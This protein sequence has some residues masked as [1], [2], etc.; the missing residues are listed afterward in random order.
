MRTAPLPPAP[1][2]ARGWG[3]GRGI[4]AGVTSFIVLPLSSQER[5]PGGE[6][7]RMKSTHI[8]I[9]LLAVLAFT[10]HAESLSD[11][12]KSLADANTPAN[13]LFSLSFFFDEAGRP[14]SAL[15]AIDRAIE[16]DATVPGYFARKGQLLLARKRTQEAADAYGH[17]ADMDPATKSFRGAQARAYANCSMNKEASGAWEKLLKLC[18][19][20]KEIL[21]AAN[22]LAALQK[23]QFDWYAAEKAWRT[24]W[25]KLDSWDDRLHAAQ[26]LSALQVELQ[27]TQRVLGFWQAWFNAEKDWQHAMPI[28]QNLTAYAAQV[29]DA[30]PEQLSTITADW[31]SVLTLAPNEEVRRAAAVGFGE[32]CISR[33]RPDGVSIL[34]EMYREKPIKDTDMDVI[35]VIGRAYSMEGDATKIEEF[36]RRVLNSKLSYEGRAEAAT[37]LSAS[38]RDSASAVELRRQLAKDFPE[39]FDA[40]TAFAQA[41]TAAKNFDE[42]LNVYR[43]VLPKARKD[44]ENPQRVLSIYDAMVDVCA[45]A[46]DADRA[47]KLIVE[48]LTGAEPWYTQRWLQLLNST[49]G[50]AAAHA[51]AIRIAEAGGARR[52]GAGLYL[53]NTDIMRARN[54]LRDA[55]A[56]AALSV[57]QRYQ[58]LN[59]L[60]NYSRS[61]TESIGYTRRML[62]LPTVHWTRY[63]DYQ[64]L[65]V[66]LGQEGLVKDGIDSV[67]EAM[68]PEQPDQNIQSIAPNTL[69]SLGLNIW[70]GNG[71]GRGLR[72]AEQLQEAMRAATSLYRERAGDP[73]FGGCFDQLCQTLAD[74]CARRGDLA[75]GV[76]FLDD[77]CA[78]V[79]SPALHLDAAELL[80]RNLDDFGAW[81]EYLA[82][83][84][85]LAAEINHTL[86]LNN[87]RQYLPGL[88]D[89]F[90]KFVT[91]KKKT[92]D[93]RRHIVTAMDKAQGNARYAQAD[94]LLGFVRAAGKPEDV[95][96][97]LKELQDKQIDGPFFKAQAAW[98]AGAVKM[99][100]STSRADTVAREQLLAS[101]ESWK[102]TLDQN[103]EDYQ[104][105]INLYKV[106][107]QLGR[108]TDGQPFL[109]KALQIAPKDPLVLECHARELMLDKKYGEAARELIEAAHIA[110]RPDDVEATIESAY[111]LS[112]RHAD[113]IK[114]ALDS[115]SE[116]HNNG[117]GIRDA[118]AI[119]DLAERSNG[120]EQL[121]AELMKRFDSA[122][123]DKKFV[124]ESV[125]RLGLRV[126]WERHDTDVATRALDALLALAWR[127]GHSSNDESRWR[128]LSAQAENRRQINDAI[129]IQQALMTA[130]LRRQTMPHVSEYEQLARLMILADQPNDAADL[131][132]DGMELALQRRAAPLSGRVEIPWDEKGG[133]R[134]GRASR[135]VGQR[136]APRQ[137]D[138]QAP[139]VRAILGL[140]ANEAANGAGRFRLAGGHRFATL[141]DAELKDFAAHPADY[142]GALTEPGLAVNLGV[143]E[144]MEA[145]FA[146]PASPETSLA[147]AE[148][149]AK[150]V[151]GLPPE[152]RPKNATLAAI[153]SACG[154][155]LSPREDRSIN[156][157]KKAE[158]AMRVAYLYESLLNMPDETRLPGVK[159]ELALK[160]YDAAAAAAPARY[161]LEATRAALMLAQRLKLNESVLTYT[162]KLH[163]AYPGCHGPATDFAE[164]LLANG[165]A[166]EAIVLLRQGLSADDSAA[167]CAGP[168]Y[169][170]LTLAGDSPEACDGA[171][172]FFTWALAARELEFGTQLDAD[173]KPLLDPERG[174]LK[175][176]LAVA[177][178]GSAKIDQALKAL[179]EASVDAPDQTF[180]QERIKRLCVACQKAGRLNDFL[181]AIDAKIKERPHSLPLRLARADI[182]E[183]SG[184]LTA[185]IETLT[186]AKAMRAELSTVK[187]LI[188]AQRKSGDNAAALAE[189]R[190]WS[191][192]FPWDEEAHRTLAAIYHDL[193]DPSGEIQALT[194]LVESAPREAAQCRAVAAAMIERKDFS[195]ARALLER[196][197]EL[198][199]E[200]PWR[201][202]DLAEACLLMQDYAKAGELCQDALTRDWR[203]GLSPELLARTP[204]WTGTF[205]ARA[206]A[207]LAEAC[208]AT[209]QT[210]KAA[211]ERMQLPAGYKRPAFDKAAPGTGVLTAGIRRR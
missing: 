77:L 201:V 203:K 208:Q 48:E 101:L 28:M 136:Y 43:A 49:C 89:P 30:T 118:D 187:R 80:Q 54:M 141:L 110:G 168:G 112:G 106:Y 94:L 83:N 79:D 29:G 174:V 4:Y 145:A 180:E 163:T 34:A 189:C 91:E 47:T 41:L 82:Y 149:R 18:T 126:A 152:R 60:R 169:L 171:A 102:K 205:E 104:A 7:K 8:V 5:G 176:Q 66:Y 159:P 128:E 117:Q 109:D 12:E 142:G 72:T 78:S 95:L 196:A 46:A 161:G 134:G 32:F 21:D 193:N 162:R 71:V 51:A 14:F 42:A 39:N 197:I 179:S 153:T 147:G 184:D 166:A 62:E 211:H 129:R 9:F 69:R 76:K 206:H 150:L 53:L 113:A 56:D 186:V 135:D 175:A 67:R 115:L 40:Q 148:W 207:L 52:M 13:T 132:F 86:E 37:A 96:A 158:W 97:T 64:Q 178:T 88:A 59:Q 36:W 164:S 2:P 185:L 38:L 16:K 127:P 210:E 99:N 202:V 65:A 57:E 31:L 24:A 154:A 182:L 167:V 209:G 188:A 19:A 61:K 190:L 120:V 194:M 204:N 131:M 191:T 121:R 3:D 139:W 144:P 177:L 137:P 199:V 103:P 84:D 44:K 90:V 107:M 17:A 50:E 68:K 105:A 26:E 111:E 100:N 70:Q 10:A 200:E 181:A 11:A 74:L 27:A 33:G 55:G 198:R 130:Q 119:L 195:R 156:P 170:C 20:D 25:E 160:A 63:S 93:L 140:A 23:K 75:G 122:L 151:L 146:G 157:T 15:R 22:N 35:R 125:A 192:N 143:M 123:K 87:G 1:S 58:A 116:G 165:K 98:A 173:G 124:P 155:V 114:L 183:H 172:E 73:T 85:A 45:Q 81:R 92:D 138:V 133:F 6:V 108:K